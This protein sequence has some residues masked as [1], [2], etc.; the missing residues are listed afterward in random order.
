MRGA[1]RLNAVLLGLALSV[2]ATV[3]I[4]ESVPLRGTVD[5]R[6]RTTTFNPDEVYKLTGLVG[7]AIELILEDGETFS[8]TGG[9]DLRRHTIQ[10]PGQS[11]VPKPQA[12]LVPP[13][14]GA[15]THPPPPRF[16]YA[17]T[18]IPPDRP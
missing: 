18:L 2:V 16:H 5:S 4:A 13:H 14:L 17:V 1:S 15:C 12:P 8:G 3:S 6:I 11:V 7:Y 9:G 10:A